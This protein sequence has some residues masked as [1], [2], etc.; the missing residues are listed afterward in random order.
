MC[1]IVIE[2]VFLKLGLF[3]SAFS[4]SSEVCQC[5]FEVCYHAVAW[6]PGSLTP[7]K[8]ILRVF[9]L[10]LEHRL[11]SWVTATWILSNIP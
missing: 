6:L 8:D 2:P 3:R 4:H 5:S 1:K 11:L 10:R 7:H 9:S